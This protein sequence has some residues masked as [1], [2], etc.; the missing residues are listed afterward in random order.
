VS[1]NQLW[2]R[3]R[4]VRVYAVAC[5]SIV[6]VAPGVS[7]A[8]Q[9]HLAGEN[10]QHSVRDQ[11]KEGRL[12]AALS[13]VEE[14]LAANPGDLEAHGWRGR[15]LAWKGRWAEAE[16]EY[17]WVLQQAPKDTD[18]LSALADVLVWQKKLQSAL[19]IIEE[20]RAGSPSDQEIQL[21]RARI[22]RALGRTAEAR[23]QFR[24]V[25]LLNPGSAEAKSGL[26][27]LKSEYKHELRFGNDVDSFN[28][29]DT[30]QTQ[31]IILNSRWTE[32]WSTLVTS[33][34]YQRFGQ[35]AQK[36]G[37]SSTVR[38]SGLQWLRIGGAGANDHGI[39]PRSEAWFEYGHSFRLQNA[40]FRG[41]EVSYQQR[42]LWY[43]GAHVLAL[44]LAQTYYL[45]R[46]WTWNLTV[47][48]ARSG[49]T[50]TGVDWV[51]SGS[52]RLAFPLHPH[53]SGNLSFAV[54]SESYA[55][56]DQIG[57]FSA[58][59]FA[60]GLRFRFASN[61][62]ISGYVARQNRS[63]NRSQTSYGV[64]YGICF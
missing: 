53:L 59:T 7:L 19:E 21:R 32:R 35:Q 13:T 64:S 63:Q 50:G 52:A 43:A 17:Q 61:Q 22:L 8:A 49:F 29:T 18:M 27:S 47:T 5:L 12:D 39:V 16:G 33:N 45:P 20:A 9:Q 38:V 60:G 51:P 4:S 55:Q 3:A 1:A 26:S 14:R 40:W 6:L 36:F 54:G 11:V 10:W 28:Y 30:A 15:L 58:R 62:D 42:W 46:D 56:V 31:S 41:V 2:L 48:G 34:I 44:A 37:A 57:R 25:L 23:A 24:E